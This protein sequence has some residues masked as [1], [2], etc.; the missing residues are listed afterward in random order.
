MARYQNR[1]PR[2]PCRPP[3]HRYRHNEMGPLGVGRQPDFFSFCPDR[4][5]LAWSLFSSLHRRPQAKA[6]DRGLRGCDP[7]ALSPNSNQSNQESASWDLFLS[8][9]LPGGYRNLA[10]ATGPNP[11]NARYF[12]KGICFVVIK[13]P[14]RSLSAGGPRRASLAS[15][16][17]LGRRLCCVRRART[18]PHRRPGPSFVSCAL[19]RIDVD[20]RDVVDA[21][22]KKRQLC[23]SVGLAA[24][25]MAASDTLHD[26]AGPPLGLRSRGIVVGPADSGRADRRQGL[27][28]PPLPGLLQAVSQGNRQPLTSSQLPRCQ[29]CQQG[30]RPSAWL[31]DKQQENSTQP[32]GPNVTPTHRQLLAWA[33]WLATAAVAGES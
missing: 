32:K 27:Q 29:Q 15:R 5:Q 21:G 30:I 19:S 31:A 33:P 3:G 11:G 12:T 9:R 23:R 26:S 6:R 4:W 25:P 17:N 1:S 20:C 7:V 22:E 16:L 18:R 8:S 24:T 10:G 13:M 14:P 28:G 2:S